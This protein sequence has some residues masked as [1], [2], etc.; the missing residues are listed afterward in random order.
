MLKQRLCTAGIPPG[1]LR[2]RASLANTG[3][4]LLSV[5]LI[6]LFAYLKR[7]RRVFNAGALCV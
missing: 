6:I 3:I 1:P 7:A 2:D 4:N 5:D